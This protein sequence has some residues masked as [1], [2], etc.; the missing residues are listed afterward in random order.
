M[1]YIVAIPSYNRYDK[2]VL[3]TLQMLKN[4]AVK[5]SKIFIFVANKKEYE[6]F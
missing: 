2:L 6:K 1:T 3:K 4:G 5:K